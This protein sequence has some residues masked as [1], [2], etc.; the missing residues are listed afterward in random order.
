VASYIICDIS[1]INYAVSETNYMK[2]QL[3]ADKR[4]WD[5]SLL[6]KA[7]LFFQTYN[8]KTKDWKLQIDHSGHPT[9]SK[10]IV[11]GKIFSSSSKDIHVF[12]TIGSSDGTLSIGAHHITQS[13]CIISVRSASKGKSFDVAKRNH[14]IYVLALGT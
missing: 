14:K 10:S 1:E 6:S 12:T 3:A 7:V 11:F 5:Q 8:L 13:G 2:N 4:K 9:L